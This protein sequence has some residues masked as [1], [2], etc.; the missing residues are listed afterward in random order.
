MAEK[1]PTA[2]QPYRAGEKI[3][4]IVLEDVKVQT[5]TIFVEAPASGFEEFLPRAQKLLKTVEWE[6]A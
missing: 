5:V 3:R 2:G 6:G 4:F 1:E